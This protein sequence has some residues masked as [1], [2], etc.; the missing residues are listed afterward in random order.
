M[1]NHLILEF[2]NGEKQEDLT[3]GNALLG[4]FKSYLCNNLIA[5]KVNVIGPTKDNFTLPQILKEILGK[6]KF[7]KDDSYRALWISKDEDL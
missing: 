2:C 7:S 6:F 3:R 4:Q 5:T 1:P